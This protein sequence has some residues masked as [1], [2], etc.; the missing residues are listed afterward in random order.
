MTPPKAYQDKNNIEANYITNGNTY[1]FQI[2]N[3]N[4]NQE[5]IIDPILKYSTYLGGTSYD[6]GYGIAVDNTGSAYITGYTGSTNYPTTPGAYQNTNAGSSDAF[7]AK[8]ALMI[9]T[10]TQTDNKANF[11]GQNVDLTAQV[12]DDNG[13][14]VNEKQVAFSVNGGAVGT[15]NVINGEAT[16]T[17]TIPTTWTAGD[18]PILADY[19]GTAHY[20]ASADTTTLTVNPTSSVYLTITG[21][22]KPVVGETVTYTLKVG[23]RGPD[24][25]ENV[26]MTYTIP[27]GLEFAGS[28]VDVGTWIYDPA[29]RT[30]TWTIGEVPVGALTC[31]WT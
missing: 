7:V 4:Q 13:N 23:N 6:Y 29:T 2:G 18:Y 24:P 30:I 25:A 11:A 3:Y 10:D 31:I 14:N 26:V 9:D 5:L 17:W 21:N 22:E 12:K 28:T 8:L 16:Y 1:Q 19:L 15:V 27:E 20:A